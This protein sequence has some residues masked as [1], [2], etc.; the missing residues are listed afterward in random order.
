[1]ININKDKLEQV[2]L[3]E[4]SE[5]ESS[6]IFLNGEV[7]IYGDDRIQVSIKVTVDESEFNDEIND[8][9]VCITDG[10]KPSKWIDIVDGEPVEGKHYWVQFPDGEIKMCQL[11][12]YKKHGCQYNYWQG[13]DGNDIK[14]KATKFIEIIKPTAD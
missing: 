7:C 5:I 2:I 4:M 12:D 13:R 11:N 8:K 3:N 6:P 1:M 9:F 14:L 10:E